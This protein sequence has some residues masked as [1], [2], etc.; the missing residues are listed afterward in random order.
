VPFTVSVKPELP[1]AIETGEMEVV[2]GTGFR[3]VK[4]CAFEVPPPGAGFTTVTEFVPAFA[5]SVLVIVAVSC[6]AETKTV[7]LATPFQS[8][9]DEATKFVPFTVSVKSE[10]PAVVEVGVI[11]VVVGTGFVIVKVSEFDVPPPGVGFTTVT[12]T[13]PPA[14]TSDARIVAVKVVLEM[15]LVVRLKPPHSTCDDEMK[16]VPVSVSVKPELPAAVDVGEIA[17]ST[18]VGFCGVVIVNVCAFEVPPPGV[19]F[20]TVTEAIPV[21]FTSADVIVAVTCVEE[22]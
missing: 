9:V 15:K 11:E 13:V 3:T 6:A 8:T 16:P 12:E 21:A 18:G 19:G 5:M 22:T 17:V 7:D 4:V 1:A 14:A 2:V 20:T 10:L